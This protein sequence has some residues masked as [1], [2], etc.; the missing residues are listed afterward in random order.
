[1]CLH[2]SIA[3]NKDHFHAAVVNMSDVQYDMQSAGVQVSVVI[4]ALKQFFSELREPVI[5][6][7]LYEDLKDAVS[8]FMTSSL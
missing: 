3:V 6:L 4:T 8:K 1:M 5:P 2:V 7:S